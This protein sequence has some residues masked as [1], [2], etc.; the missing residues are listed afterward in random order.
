MKPRLDPYQAAPEAM[1]AVAALDTNV[2]GSGLEPRL[3]E[4][5]KMRAS[6]INGCAY[7]CT[8]TPATPGLRAKPRSGFTCSTPGA[9]HRFTPIES[10]QRSGGPRQ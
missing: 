8:C 10:A 4:L 9:S 3:V 1:K 6:Q 2:Q 5:I 7:C